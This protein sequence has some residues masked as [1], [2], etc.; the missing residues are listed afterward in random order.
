MAVN[1]RRPGEKAVVATAW[2]VL[3]VAAIALV[4]T[5]FLKTVQ[6]F[7]NPLPASLVQQIAPAVDDQSSKYV[8]FAKAMNDG[9]DA[10]FLTLKDHKIERIDPAVKQLE[11]TPSL[12]PKADELR[13]GLKAL[14]VREKVATE[15]SNVGTAR[16]RQDEQNALARDFNEWG[17]QYNAWLKTTG[18]SYGIIEVMETSSPAK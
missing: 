2:R 18:R 17:K 8:F 9:Q 5:S 3:Q 10:F 7:R 16:S 6:H 4:A 11:T 13:D 12:D 1:Y 15:N 14:L